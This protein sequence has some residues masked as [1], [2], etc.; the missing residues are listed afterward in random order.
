MMTTTASEI[1]LFV[2]KSSGLVRPIGWFGALAFGI[3]C[4]CLSSMIPFA[5]VTSAWPGASIIGVLFIATI[6]GLFHAYSY[7]AIGAA[8]PRSGADYVFGSRVLSAPL[9]FASSWTLVIFSGIMA[10]VLTA[11]IPAST[12]PPLFQTLGILTGNQ[13]F[14]D[15]ASYAATTQ[16][17][18]VIGII[19][20][21]LVS[22]IVFMPT[23]KV[24]RFMQFA[25]FGSLIAWAIIYFSLAV[26][27]PESFQANWDKFMGAGSFVNR[28][29]LAES[30]GMVFSTNAVGTTLAGLIMGFWIFYGYYISTFFAGEVN[31]TSKNL[32][33][34]S[35]GSLVTSSII[36][37][38][39]AV[40]LQRLVSLKFLS[41]E[42]YL[43]SYVGEVFSMPWITF[44]A[45]VAYPST[46]LA[47]VMA[48]FWILGVVALSVTY[49]FYTSR[50]V[51]A[52]AFD[53]IV[54]DGIAYVNPKTNVPTVTI[55]ITI[56]LA[57]VGLIDAASGGLIAAHLAF[58][59][60]AVT[61]QLVAII[62]ITL[63][64]F[65]KPELFEKAPSIVSKR[66]GKVPIITII[67]GVT[68]I[69]MLWLIVAAFLYPAVGGLIDLNTIL[70][71]VF[72]FV[73]GLVVYYI[74][75]WYRKSKEGIDIAQ[76]YKEL[77]PV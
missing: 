14:L 51:F 75:K 66:I 40:L 3:H 27:S 42:G 10:G 16:G 54:P 56:V 13:A 73:S 36:F 20:L 77:P 41:A 7:A 29:P 1:K 55:V 48:I 76:T 43:N 64:A 6:L 34:G 60:F 4:I 74:S 58:A 17:I 46:F 5:W 30:N 62:A 26:A 28:I 32:F 24:V 67:G 18:V 65:L 72:M 25:F 39:G 53:R 38:I 19:F 49:F 44:Y 70:T 63:F 15:F 69:Y 52:W 31:N 71:L 37:I 45:S 9:S 21:V 23:K 61:T 2:R 12:F 33:I 11:W 68:L 47:W 57:I 50:I 59:F 22:A 8:M 35:A